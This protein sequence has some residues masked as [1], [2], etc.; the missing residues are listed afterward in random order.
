MEESREPM[1]IGL[2]RMGKFYYHIGI[3]YEYY[4]KNVPFVIQLLFY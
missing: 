3:D 4:S 2:S 1:K